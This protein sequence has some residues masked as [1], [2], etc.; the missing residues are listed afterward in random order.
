MKRLSARA[1]QWMSLALLLTGFAGSAAAAPLSGVLT[2]DNAYQLWLGTSAQ[3]TTKIAED[4]NCTAADIFLQPE[5]ISVPDVAGAEYLYLVAYSDDADRQGA[6]GQLTLGSRTLYTGDAPWE[7]F[8]TGLDHDPGC[9]GASGAPSTASIDQQIALANSNAGLSQ[10]SGGWVGTTGTSLGRLAVGEPNDLPG[11]TYQLATGI[12]SQARWMWFDSRPPSDAF[13]GGNHKEYLIFRL[14]LAALAVCA[15]PPRGLVG[16]WSLDEAAGTTASEIIASHNGTHQGNPTPLPAGKVGGALQFDGV[17][18]FVTVPDANGL[19][20]G[21]APGGD[22]TIDAWVRTTDA[23]GVGVLVEKRSDPATPRGYS[24]FLLNGNLGFQLGTG[25]G[26]NICSSNPQTSGCTNYG[27]NAFVADGQWH[28]VAVTVD[29][30]AADGGRWYVDGVEVGTRFDPTIRSASLANSGPLVLGRVIAGFI[31]AGS[32]FFDGALDEVEIFN[33][34]LTPAEILALYEA[35]GT[36]KCKETIHVSWDRP[37]CAGASTA[38]ANP[39]ICNQSPQ[40]QSYAVSFHGYPAAGDPRCNIDGPTSF[41]IVPPDTLPLLIA[42][43][44]CR[45]FAVKIGRPA[46]ATS[47]GRIGC[48]RIT[49]T[50]TVSGATIQAA[51]SVWDIRNYCATPRPADPTQVPVDGTD[52]IVFRVAN[53]TGAAST[54]NYEIE[55]MASDMIPENTIVTLDGLPPGASVTGQV[56]IPAGGSADIPVRAGVSELDSFSFQDV[57]LLNSATGDVLTSASVR[58]FAPGCTPGATQ[59]CLNAGR[60]R[61]AVAW[62]DFQGNE[63]AGNSIPLTGDTGYF[64]FFDSSNVELVVKV[65]DGRDLTDSWWVFYGALSTVEYTLSVTDTL[66][67]ATRTY[68][69]PSGQLASVGDTGGV[70]DENDGTAFASLLEGAGS[71]IVSRTDRLAFPEVGAATAA[72][73][74]PTPT[75]LCLNGSRFRIEVEWKDFQG[76]MGVGQAVPLTSD[77][78]YFWFFDDDNVELIIKVLD[79]RTLTGH[80]WIFYG[81]LSSVE[82]RITVT[83]TE[84]GSTKTYF[85]PSGNLG[86][87]ADTSGIPD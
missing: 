11:G 19:D 49:A 64:W 68:F 29:R 4:E 72:T 43:G 62:R 2:A 7:V 5:T 33:R 47:H 61:V 52:N 8:A 51:G 76:N 23:S 57:L 15:T 30:D 46:G 85:N 42:P 60:F 14:P 54:L 20:F 59:L 31:G 74:N 6:L 53:T 66:T 41:S 26:T 63:G 22:F 24:F 48:Y 18:D 56:T 28:F 17:D 55:G 9:G 78:G 80:W 16:W 3:V 12:D 37:L 82:Y 79:G 44:S 70:P 83:D 27:S 34:A 69:N 73:C 21:A 36:G 25:S 71:K 40:Q 81:A 38:E 45:S 58:A 77:T 10:S 65:L 75:S 32:S 67:G 35:D 13:R 86:S 50:N 84:T 87:R 1:V 39:M